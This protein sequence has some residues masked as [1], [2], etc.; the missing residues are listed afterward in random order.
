[1]SDVD[2]IKAKLEEMGIPTGGWAKSSGGHRPLPPTLVR[3]RALLEKLRG[4]VEVQVEKDKEKLAELYETMNRLK[5]G[6]GR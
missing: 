6:G 4:L 5:H 1:M 2:D 3:Q